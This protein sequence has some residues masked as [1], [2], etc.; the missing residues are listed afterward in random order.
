MKKKIVVAIVLVTV[1]LLAVYAAKTAEDDKKCDIK[2]FTAFFDVPGVEKDE[3]NEIMQLIAQK[4]GARCREQWLAG[5]SSEE[6]IASFIASGEYTDFISGNVTLYEAGALI[7]I[8][9]YWDN[10]PNIKNFMP[11]EQWDRFRQSD[12]H[13]YWIPQFGV[14]QGE[15]AEVVHEGEAFWIQ[16]RVLKWAGYPVIETIDE[17]FSLLESYAAANPVMENPY[18]PGEM[19][20]NIPFT[21]LCDDWR[22]FCLEN[23]PQFLDG[24]P[25]DGSC[26]VDTDTKTVLDYNTSETARRYFEKLNEEYHKGIVDQ[27]FFTQSYE[28]Y[29]QKLASGRVLGMVDQW[30][31]FAY[32]TNA[33]LGN[34]AEQGCGYVPL[35]ITMDKGTKNQWH[36]KRGTELSVADGISI[37]ISCEDVEGAMKFIN[38]LLD[39][40]ILKLRYWGMEQVDYKVHENGTY[41]R[42]TEQRKK[43]QDLEYG[44]SHYCI[45]PYFPR[46]EGML[47]DGINAFSPEYQPEEFFEALAPDVKECLEA[48]GCKCYVDM[49]GTNDEPGP[50]YPMYSYSDMLTLDSEAGRVWN[51]M[52]SVKK[53]YLPRVVMADN[54]NEMWQQYMQQYEACQPEIF[55][56]EMQSELERRVK[57]A[58]H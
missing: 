49:L 52:G 29:L 17:Y 2:E 21:V 41:Y 18:H 5:K 28:E 48:Y 30:W 13:I 6:A 58:A 35:P 47:S 50:W 24:Y 26:M 27:E 9:L 44:A 16:T 32:S 42:T 3:N 22:Y 57:A 37:T 40:E 43:A 23:P 25:N 39:E 53:D 54:F 38:D 51:K 55:F 36:V 33:S 4:T 11:P 46:I 10:Y 20:Q 31:Q 7:A 12:G 1:A 34:M 15:S 19:M 8:D 45:Y 14:V 56:A